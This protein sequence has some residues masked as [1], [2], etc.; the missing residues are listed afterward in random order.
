MPVPDNELYLQWCVDPIL[1][2]L[3]RQ[4][5]PLLGKYSVNAGVDLDFSQSRYAT[6]N[7][8]LLPVYVLRYEVGSKSGVCVIDAV[9]A[10]TVTGK[11][12]RDIMG[13][14]SRWFAPFAAFFTKK[15]AKQVAAPPK[16]ITYDDDAA[17][18]PSEVEAN[19]HA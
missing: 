4:L 16:L 17:S 10:S 8:T 6:L 7:W 9:T 18:A 15:P 3:K 19:L 1:K 14:I 5:V 2:R 11:K 12:V 13:G